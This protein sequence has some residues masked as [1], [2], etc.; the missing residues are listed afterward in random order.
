MTI[1]AMFKDE[2]FGLIATIGFIYYLLARMVAVTYFKKRDNIKKRF[3]PDDILAVSGVIIFI[4]LIGIRA[5]LVEILPNITEI[6]IEN[7]PVKQGMII[8]W[9]SPPRASI[10]LAI[11]EE[12]GTDITMKYEMVNIRVDS[13][14]GEEMLIQYADSFH[15]ARVLAIGKK[16]VAAMLQ[17]GIPQSANVMSNISYLIKWSL[18][19]TLGGTLS[20]LFRWFKPRK[21]R[22]IKSKKLRYAIFLS[23]L[24]FGWMNMFI[25]VFSGRSLAMEQAWGL[26]VQISHIG[27]IVFFILSVAY[28]LPWS[29][30]VEAYK[31]WWEH[32]WDPTRE[33][34]IY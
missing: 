8:E 30:I 24:G 4:S 9:T 14:V 7:W 18:T 26:L 2:W 11:F 15:S 23:L 10:P 32:R 22:L 1:D 20:V 25:I 3:S 27:L 19:V 12:Y 5:S 16:S 13:Y 33:G 28:T 29:K 6:I 31:Y 34:E 21:E 17:N